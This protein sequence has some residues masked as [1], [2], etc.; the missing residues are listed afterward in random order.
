MNEK[1][2]KLEDQIWSEFEK[3][4]KKDP[5]WKKEVSKMAQR[6]KEKKP[7]PFEKGLKKGFGGYPKD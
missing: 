3:G 6:R 5:Q 4:Y 2:R 1:T 7:S